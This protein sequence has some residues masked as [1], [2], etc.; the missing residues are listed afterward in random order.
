MKN[1]WTTIATRPITAAD[2]ERYRGILQR[3][4]SEDRY[5]RFFHF[6]DHFDEEFVHDFVRVRPDAIGFIAEEGTEAL[7]AAHAFSLGDGRAELAIVVARDARRRG[8]GRALVERIKAELQASAHSALVA[9][10]LG[11]NAGFSRL[12]RSAGMRSRGSESGVTTWEF[13]CVPASSD[14]SLSTCFG[15]AAG[16][17]F[18]GTAADER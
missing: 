6:V 2:A 17:Q 7:G 5:C 4:T 13:A 14:R 12:A 16:L 10:A 3:T 11:A 1:V 18:G 15:D 9:Y 8:V